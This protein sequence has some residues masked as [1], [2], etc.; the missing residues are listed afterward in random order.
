MPTAKLFRRIMHDPD[1][2]L[3]LVTDVEKYP[4]FINLMSQ[5]RVTK[6]QTLS[7][8]H[9]RFEADAVVSYKFL[10]ETFRSVVDVY[11]DKKHVCVTK[12]GKAGAVRAL[13]NDWVF[14]PL[15][16]G[17]TLVEFDITVQLKALPLDM[18]LRRNFDQMSQH[19]VKLF[20]QR[21]K[22]MLKPVGDPTLDLAGE[23][24]RLGLKNVVLV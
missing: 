5:T 2:L 22:V 17:S 15:S 16:D 8:H 7:E 12:P 24:A 19:I 14:H 9:D 1:A 3:S 23:Y 6:H 4:K 21:A 18:M 20:D 10:N 13:S 11:K